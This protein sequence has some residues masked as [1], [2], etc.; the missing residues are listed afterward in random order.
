MRLLES[1]SYRV[2]R[3]EASIY[4][5]A[6][7]TVL[8][9]FLFQVKH[10]APIRQ[11]LLID[12]S[13]EHGKGFAERCLGNMRVDSVAA[14]QQLLKLG[15][16]RGYPFQDEMPRRQ[17]AAQRRDAVQRNLIT[18]QQMVQHREHHHSIEVACAAAQ[19]GR[20]LSVLPSCRG[21][22]MCKGDT[23]WL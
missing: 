1:P 19:E 8:D 18:Q 12:C 9:L 17:I 7:H 22:W 4:R 2:A 14:A 11:R 20:I 21:R 10:D 23:Q 13:E 3:T 6:S 5:L 15:I 16:R